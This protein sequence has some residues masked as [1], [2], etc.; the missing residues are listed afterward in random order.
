MGL[1]LVVPI[2]PTITPG[3]LH[4]SAAIDDL[5]KTVNTF[6]TIPKNN[7][8]KLTKNQEIEETI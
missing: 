5:F 6:A 3:L 4:I 2:L 1:D 8:I 7:K